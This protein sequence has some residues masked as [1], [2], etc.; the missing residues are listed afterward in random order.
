[1]WYAEQTD[2]LSEALS[3]GDATARHRLI[4]LHQKLA[5]K[6][7]YRY[8]RMYGLDMDDA[9]QIAVIGL[10]EAARRFR[11]EYGYQF[12]TYAT[13]WVRQ[14]CQRHVPDAVMPIRAPSYVYG[15][16]H[17]AQR[18]FSTLSA[19]IGERQAF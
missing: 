5:R 16:G 11:P 6:I 7:A 17:Q 4:L 9:E 2:A 8:H 15:P 12:S 13:W 3:N 19:G 18:A 1:P 10:I 14:A